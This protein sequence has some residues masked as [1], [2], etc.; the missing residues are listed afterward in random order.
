MRPMPRLHFGLTIAVLIAA[1][2]TTET[3]GPWMA[4]PDAPP[5][6]G[7]HAYATAFAAMVLVEA[8][9]ARRR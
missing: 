8:D 6:A 7:T 9:A 5:S 2:W 3:L 1:A 4:H